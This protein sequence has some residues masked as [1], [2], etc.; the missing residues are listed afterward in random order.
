[1]VTRPTHSPGRTD[2]NLERLL[3]SATHP[4][5]H[6]APPFGANERTL[7]STPQ[8]AN[9]PAPDMVT[10][11]QQVFSGDVALQCSATER[12]RKMLSK[13]RNPPIQ[14]VIECGV[15]PYFVEFL[16]RADLPQLQF[17]AAWAL[18]NIASG[19]REQ[20]ATVIDAGA[21]PIFINLLES[22]ADDV[23]EQAVWALGNIAGDGPDCRDRVLQ[24]GVLAPLL[25]LLND[26]SSKVTM[27]RNAT[28]SL[29]NLCRGKNPP[30]DFA[31]VSE[32]L[33]TL[34]RLMYH[35]DDEVLTDAC[36]A[37]SY[38]TDGTNDKIQRVIEAGVVPRLVKLLAHHSTNIITPALRSIGNI[39][40][41]DSVQTQVVLDCHAVP[42]LARLLTHTKETIKKE[43]CWTISN[44]TAGS[45]EQIQAV[46]DGN[47]IPTVID[48]LQ[49]SDFKTRK[50]AAWAISNATSGGRPAQIQQI[51]AAGCIPPLCSILAVGDHKVIEVALEALDNILRVG[52]NAYTIE[53]E[54]CGGLDMIEAVQTSAD[55]K[56]Q[57]KAHTLI[58]KYF[59]PASTTSTTTTSTTAARTSNAHPMIV[60]VT[61]CK[62]GN[63][64]LHGATVKVPQ[65]VGKSYIIEDQSGM[66]HTVQIRSTTLSP[67]KPSKPA[68]L[69]EGNLLGGAL[70]NV[71]GLDTTNNVNADEPTEE[72]PTTS[73]LTTCT[74]CPR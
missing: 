4:P 3:A 74:F 11:R 70:G 33:Q 14:Q 13:E 21:I 27:F 5:H 46:I 19:A 8:L 17:E 52:V 2:P 65:R 59:T 36:W 68:T 30:P 60:D 62:S 31:V 56:L 47:L 35:T 24:S 26:N 41:G 43:A 58:A 25:R 44:I 71:G 12:F 45:Q 29:S 50:E 69:Y 67:S 18:T 10:L 23:R 32:S 49:H 16:K 22:P 7:V 66:E 40:T 55:E 73:T 6:S 51:V 15:V 48:V 37:L 57:Q 38:L 61:G 9:E 39:V 34:A 1:M 54:E 42:G 20:T 28:W 64:K 63:Q 53:I 72:V